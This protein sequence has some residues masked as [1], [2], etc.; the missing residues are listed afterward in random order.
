LSGVAYWGFAVGADRIYYLHNASD[1]ATEIRQFLL[2]TGKD[3]RIAAIG[4]PLTGGLSLSPDGKS[5][6]YAEWRTRGTLMLAET[7]H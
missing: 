1:G 3:S 2:V 4:K 7:V 5:L 6:I